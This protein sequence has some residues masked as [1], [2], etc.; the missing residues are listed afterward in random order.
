MFYTVFWI[1][2]RMFWP[3]QIRTNMRIR[4][5]LSRNGQKL[6]GKN[7]FLPLPDP[8]DDICMGP[9]PDSHQNDT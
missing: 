1:R 5:L 9:D 8:H 3:V 2:I 7:H 4:M 6:G